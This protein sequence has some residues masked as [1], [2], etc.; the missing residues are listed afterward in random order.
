MSECEQNLETARR[1]LRTI[2]MGTPE[3]AVSFFAPDV[4][5]RWYPHKLAPNGMTANLVTMRAAA[6]RGKKLMTS[7]TYEVRNKQE[8]T[9]PTEGPDGAP[10]AKRWRKHIIDDWNEMRVPPLGR[11][12]SVG[13]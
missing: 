2:E 13:M 8:P 1:Y 5:A 7:Q 10:G 12:P 3:E 4:V 11:A 9:R 6:E